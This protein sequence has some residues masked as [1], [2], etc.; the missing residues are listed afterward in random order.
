[1]PGNYIRL[2]DWEIDWGHP[3]SNGTHAMA[4][5][6]VSHT[7]SAREWHLVSTA[8]LRKLGFNTAIYKKDSWEVDWSKRNGKK[9]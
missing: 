9:V 4:R 6:T 2:L 7:A 1:M 8:Y 3:E 5:N